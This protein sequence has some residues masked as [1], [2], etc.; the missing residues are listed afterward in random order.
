LEEDQTA[1]KGWHQAFP[2]VVITAE[3]LMADGD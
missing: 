2:D 1:L 3:K